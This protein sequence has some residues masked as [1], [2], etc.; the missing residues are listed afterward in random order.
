M[1]PNEPH[2]T[3]HPFEAQIIGRHNTKKTQ[4]SLFQN[5]ILPH[6]QSIHGTVTFQKSPLYTRDF[7]N[8]LINDW[9]N[10]G[11]KPGTIRTLVT[12]LKKYIEWETGQTIKLKVSRAQQQEVKAW[13]KEEAK[14]A[15]ETCK[16]LDEDFYPILM[17]A[18]N[19]GMRKGEIFGLQYRD[20]DFVKG[21]IKVQRSYSGQTKNGKSRIIPMN[22]AVAL[23]MEKRYPV[24][25]DQENLFKEID[26]NYKLTRLC[27]WA[28]IT[29]IPFHGLRHTFATFLLED[30]ISPKKVQRLLGHSHVSTTVD[31]YWHTDEEDVDLSGLPQ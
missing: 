14:K 31:L 29:R 6:L 26:V 19:T 30:G 13:T 25:Q 4:I 23:L 12:V 27:K 3:E 21:K 2:K 10:H 16:H 15:I 17:F 1:R 9:E 28:E 22:D 7:C 20:V 11:L 24:G 8:R 5:W 18:L